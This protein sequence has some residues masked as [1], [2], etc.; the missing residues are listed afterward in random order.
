MT[1]EISDTFFSSVLT[2][3]V[4]ILSSCRP[5]RTYSI[6]RPDINPAILEALL[7]TTA[8]PTWF[9]PMTLG[10]SFSQEK[11]I[12]GAT[13]FNNPTSEGLEEAKRIYGSES[14]VS[15]ILSLGSGQ[16]S[17]SVTDNPGIEGLVEGIERMTVDCDKTASELARRF[18]SSSSYFRF[19]VD[20]CIEPCRVSDWSEQRLGTINSH[21]KNYLEEKSASLDC[22]VQLLIKKQSSHTLGQLSK[23]CTQRSR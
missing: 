4:A 3:P 11:L 21:T 22:A 19:S 2:T 14:T 10:R 20:K 1:N 17:P 8:N 6:G 13:G 5:L 23:Y 7:A 9:P 16:N 15:I 12:G 18:A